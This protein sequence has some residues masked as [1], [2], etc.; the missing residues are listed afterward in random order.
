MNKEFVPYELAIQLKQLGFDVPS[1]SG[2]SYP[3]SDNILTQAILFQQAFRWFRDKYNLKPQITT[4][5]DEWD[6]YIPESEYNDI[7]I[8]QSSD[9]WTYE[10]AELACLKKLIEVVEEI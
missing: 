4:T 1:V 2:Y 7:P 3:D 9:T 10:D 6:F 5:W 8:R